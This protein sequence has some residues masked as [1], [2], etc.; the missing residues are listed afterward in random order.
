[1]GLWDIK[2]M[3]PCSLFIFFFAGGLA[4]LS[5]SR[6][7]IQEEAAIRDIELTL[8]NKTIDAIANTNTNLTRLKI[9]PPSLTGACDLFSGKWVHDNSSRYPLYKEEECPYLED[10]FACQ[11]YGRKDTKY[12]QWRWQPHGCD[13]PKYVSLSL[14]LSNL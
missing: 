7:N 12:L 5:F 10:T 2:T 4:T 6:Y 13:F 11:T 3:I 1:M 8:T 9:T 14:C